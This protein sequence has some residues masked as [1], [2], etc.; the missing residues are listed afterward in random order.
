M[1]KLW[2][3]LDL[4]WLDMQLDG[5]GDLAPWTL[6]A[7]IVLPLVGF[8]AVKVAF[9]RGRMAF[10]EQVLSS[11]VFLTRPRWSTLLGVAAGIASIG[12]ILL[13]ASMLFGAEIP[14]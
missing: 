2:T 5:P 8:L 1:W 3:E 12:V 7:V 10:A 6:G 11:P 13:L 14:P 9:W 4:W